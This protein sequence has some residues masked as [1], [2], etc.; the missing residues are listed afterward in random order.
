MK[1]LGG[2]NIINFKK[3]DTP[4]ENG[5]LEAHIYSGTVLGVPSHIDGHSTNFDITWD[6]FGRCQ[7]WQRKDCFIDMNYIDGDIIEISAEINRFKQLNDLLGGI[8]LESYKGFLNNTYFR[9]YGFNH[10]GKL[11]GKLKKSNNTFTRNEIIIAFN[12]ILHH[13]TKIIVSFNQNDY[14]TKENLDEL[15]SLDFIEKEFHEDGFDYDF[16]LEVDSVEKLFEY[17][18]ILEQTFDG[19]QMILSNDRPQIFIDKY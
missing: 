2:Y 17:I 1:T 18:D 15:N 9:Y 8:T 13:E 10:D 19:F 4:I 6:K 11:V 16:Y 3:L 7:N 14:E 12:E 5:I